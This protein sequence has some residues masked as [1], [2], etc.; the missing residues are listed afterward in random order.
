MKVLIVLGVFIATTAAVSPFYEK[1]V[2]FFNETLPNS[3]YLMKLWKEH[4]ANYTKAVETANKNTKT[5]AIHRYPVP[6][7]NCHTTT[8]WG[9]REAS[10]V[11]QLHP[12]DIKVVAALGDSLTAGNGIDATFILDDLIEYRGLSWSIGGDGSLDTG[13]LTLP[14]ILKKFNGVYGYSLGTGG[15][16]GSKS[17]FNV[18]DPGD[19]SYDMPEQARLLID[20]MR[21][22][23]SINFLKDWKVIT[24]FV[25]G[26]DLCASCHD[27]NKWSPVN[28]G[29]NIKQALDMLHNEVPRAFVN[30]VPIFDIAPV[31]ALST[32]FLCSLAHIMVC[33]C[34]H[35]KNN[36]GVLKSLADQYV[37]QLEDL[38][39][40]GIYDTRDDF[41]VVIQPF[42][43][44][45]LP[46]SAGSKGNIDMTYFSEDCFHFS[47]KGHGAAA[48][49]LWNNMLESVGQKQQEWHLDQEFLC[50]GTHVCLAAAH[51][52]W[53]FTTTKN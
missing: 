11:H 53:F 42:F 8:P 19:T 35:N 24:L 7:F 27:V 49:S 4:R 3:P 48:L 1:Y 20:R 39:A 6:N 46:P 13:E 31:A 38:V 15:R 36:A 32:G 34:G 51:D 14:N 21:K 28:Y 22:D 40:T 37:I 47:G 18:A 25:G 5:R 10:S 44:N 9:G 16:G 17:K 23:T 29:N 45:T 52:H 30:L 41:T 50:P 12:G 2:K 26:N 33:D 43:K